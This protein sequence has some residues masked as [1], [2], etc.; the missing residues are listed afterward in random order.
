MVSK[1]IVLSCD[2]KTGDFSASHLWNWMKPHWI[3]LNPIMFLLCLANIN[4]VGETIRNHPLFLWF[5]LYTIHLWWFC[6]WFIIV[7]T[8]LITHDV[9]PM[10][11]WTVLLG[12][13]RT[14][15]WGLSACAFPHPRNADGL[16]FS[17]EAVDRWFHWDTLGP[18]R[19]ILDG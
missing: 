3:L 17:T 9:D 14:P 8:T 10:L 19:A 4:N 12:E 7:L 6:G 16:R 1:I 15:Q 5:I 18:S 2:I 11:H 13:H